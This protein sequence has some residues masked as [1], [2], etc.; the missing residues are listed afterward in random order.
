MGVI[1][2]EDGSV[3]QLYPI[4][5]GKP[6]MTVSCGSYRLVDLVDRLGRPKQ[7]IVRPHLRELFKADF[8]EW[9]EESTDDDEPTLLVNA[10]LVPSVSSLARLQQMLKQ[11]QPGVVRSGDGLAAAFLAP[12]S[13]CPTGQLGLSSLESSLESWA[14]EPLD[15]DLELIEYPHDVVRYHLATLGENLDDRLSRDNYREIADG[16]FV[17]KGVEL[18]DYGVLDGRDGPIV[19]EEN[20]HVGPYCFLSGPAHLGAGSRVIEHAAIKDAVALGHTCKVGGEV[21]ASSIE[22]YTNKQHHGFLGHSYLGSW[23]NLGAGTCNS[24]LK[25]TYG[26][27]SME[28]GGRKVSTGMQFIGCVVGDYAKTAINTS[29]FTGKTIGACSMVYGY[30]TTNVPSFVNYARQFG[31]V[32]EIPVEVEIATQAR[33]FRRRKVVQRPCDVQLLHDMYELTR[34]ERQLANEPLSL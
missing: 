1:V 28:Y 10:R 27:V 31:Q 32:T 16:V 30:V 3:D 29:I 6:A 23:V 18:G 26:S 15:L 20:V 4:T 25:N 34:H 12:G 19:M 22:P 13:V 2:F 7:A 17:A 14:P 9:C 11:G 24:D 8:P 21:E 5:A 33:M